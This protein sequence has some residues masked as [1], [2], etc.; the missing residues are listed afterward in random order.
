M[1]KLAT[2]MGAKYRL[3]QR[4]KRLTHRAGHEGAHD[5][6]A[7]EWL[8]RARA[9]NGAVPMKVRDAVDAAR[10]SKGPAELDLSK[11]ATDQVVEDVCAALAEH[12]AISKINLQKC[13]ELTEA[14]GKVLVELAEAQIRLVLTMPLARQLEASAPCRRLHGVLGEG[15]GYT[16][17]RRFK[18]DEKSIGVHHAQRLKLLER[19]LDY[20]NAKLTLRESLFTEQDDLGRPRALGGAT[21]ALDRDAARKAVLDV[22]ERSGVKGPPPPDAFSDPVTLDKFENHCEMVLV[23]AKRGVLAPLGKDMVA[24][25]RDVVSRGSP[26]PKPPPP[27]GPSPR[28]QQRPKTPTPDIS[29]ESE[30]EEAAPAAN[31]VQALVDEDLASKVREQE[32]QLR[33]LQEK[34]RESERRVSKAPTEDSEDDDEVPY[35]PAGAPLNETL[36]ALDA[37]LPPGPSVEALMASKSDDVE[38]ASEVKDVVKAPS[39]ASSPGSFR[40]DRSWIRE[41]DNDETAEVVD[42]TAS[43]PAPPPADRSAHEE[44]ARSHVSALVEAVRP[45]RPCIM[46]R[47]RRARVGSRRD[48]LP[49][50]YALAAIEP[51]NARRR[52][53]TPTRRRANSKKTRRPRRM[54]MRKKMSPTRLQS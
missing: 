21:V 39:P 10:A 6:F 37:Q 44:R 47:W 52:R 41:E 48:A 25:A 13:K 42:A 19:L 36:K 11:V 8:R 38:L 49:Y 32:A 50:H 18:V 14:A 9:R 45:P 31:A 28:Q 16:C 33:E 43:P 5:A 17:I 24:V 27:P 7:R 30:E 22:L 20:C 4:R 3:K 15:K 26:R 2:L 35:V 54:R 29:V 12:P 53:R 23:K 34:L 46:R 1:V 40:D 51:K